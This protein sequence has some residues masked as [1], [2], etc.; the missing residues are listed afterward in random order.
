MQL[1]AE[2]R[3]QQAIVEHQNTRDDRLRETENRTL[4]KS[5]KRREKK[6][7]KKLWKKMGG[8]PPKPDISALIKTSE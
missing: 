5:I 2:T 1:E 8:P 7:K 6:E 3:K 4:S